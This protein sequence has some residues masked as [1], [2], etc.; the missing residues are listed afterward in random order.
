MLPKNRPDKKTIFE[1]VSLAGIEPASQ[2]SEGC[3]LSVGL[4]G[5]NQLRLDF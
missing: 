3:A 5:Q 4:Q 2:P 1:L